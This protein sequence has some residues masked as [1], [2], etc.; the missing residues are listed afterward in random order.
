MRKKERQNLI[1]VYV[2]VF[3]DLFRRLGRMVQQTSHQYSE[4]QERLWE[5]QGK[6]GVERPELSSFM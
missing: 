5:L 3:T 1:S 4:R 2:S 6:V